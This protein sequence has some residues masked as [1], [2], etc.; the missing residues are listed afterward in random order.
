MVWLASPVPWV[1]GNH[2][3]FLEWFK[4]DSTYMSA[5]VGPCRP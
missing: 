1:E 3:G 2:N 5:K 4:H